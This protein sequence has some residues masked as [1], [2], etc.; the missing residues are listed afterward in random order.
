MLRILF[1]I[2]F[3]AFYLLFFPIFFF[4]HRSAAPKG[5]WIEVIVDGPVVEI[6]RSSSF[7]DVGPRPV[8]LES[9][10]RAV[11]LS[12]SDPRVVGFLVRVEEL[13]AGS[14]TA[15][16]LRQ[17]LLSAKAVGKRVVVYLPFRGATREFF[18]GSAAHVLL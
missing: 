2:L 14:A 11:E 16:A 12:A 5:G 13:R 9:L 3:N 4:R 10:R 18:V 6:G 17:A 1:S 15:T 8:S 7:W